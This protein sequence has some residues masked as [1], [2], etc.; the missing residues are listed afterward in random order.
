MVRARRVSICT[1]VCSVHIPKR[2][3]HS[4]RY[5]HAPEQAIYLFEHS[6][7][8][9]LQLK[10]LKINGTYRA[11]TP[12]SYNRPLQIKPFNTLCEVFVSNLT[13]DSFQYVTFSIKEWTNENWI[14]KLEHFW[15][16]K[17]FFRNF[18]RLNELIFFIK[19]FIYKINYRC[20]LLYHF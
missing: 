9:V 2:P 10:W 12:T 8:T 4:Y 1:M 19:K 5:V 3:D 15:W 11:R 6:T 16:W 13:N 20:W 14:Q 17:I 7:C 18:L